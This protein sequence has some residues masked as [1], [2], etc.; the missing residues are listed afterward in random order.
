MTGVTLS[1]HAALFWEDFDAPFVDDQD[2][3]SSE[4]AACD[5]E[6]LQVQ[7][8]TQAE[9]EAAR[10]EGF[11]EGVRFGREQAAAEYA[12]QRGD[13]ERSMDACLAAIQ[14]QVDETVRASADQAAFVLV[15]MVA[16]LF[17]ALL[18]G[19]GAQER[20]VLMA[21]LLPR[22]KNVS[23]IKCILPVGEAQTMQ[24][25]CAR[26]GIEFLSCTEREDLA[27]GDFRVSWHGGEAARDAQGLL[28]E[29]QQILNA[30]LQQ[31]EGS[32]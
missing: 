18:T 28:Q 8:F 13:F 11:E 24:A 4:N 21:Y 32:K 23:N 19:Y 7:H 15:E 17:P 9:H 5:D 10:Q 27:S 1:P 26:Q 16:R 6:E 20:E 25:L 31:E 29:L 22:L 12:L 3:S 2:V 30:R 14:A